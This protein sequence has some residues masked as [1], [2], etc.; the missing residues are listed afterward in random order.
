[1]ILACQALPNLDLDPSQAWQQVLA[2]DPGASFLYAVVSTGI[3]CRPVAPAAALLSPTYV[4]L[5]TL[6]T[7]HRRATVHANAAHRRA[8]RLTQ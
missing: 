8:S 1:M 7:P 2:R 3:F 6:L 4:S 5:L